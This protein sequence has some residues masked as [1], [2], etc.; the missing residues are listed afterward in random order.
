MRPRLFALFHSRGQ[1]RLRVFGPSRSVSFLS[2]LK[3][4]LAQHCAFFLSKF[5]ATLLSQSVCRAISSSVHFSKPGPQGFCPRGSPFWILPPGC[6]FSFPNSILYQL[7]PENF[8]CDPPKRSIPILQLSAEQNSLNLSFEVHNLGRFFLQ[9][10][11]CSLST[12]FSRPRAEVTSHNQHVEKSNECHKCICFQT[13]NHD[14]RDDADNYMTIFFILST[15]DK[16][17]SAFVAR[18]AI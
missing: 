7:H 13:C 15:T 18:L 1:Y 4:S 14:T 6:P 8:R 11:N 2:E 16:E 10:S 9:K 3:I 12:F 5:H 17:F